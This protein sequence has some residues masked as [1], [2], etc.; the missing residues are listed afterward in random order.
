[1]CPFSAAKRNSH[2][3]DHVLANVN[4]HTAPKAL[5]HVGKIQIALCTATLPAS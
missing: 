4:G 3:E 1:M 2:T 5:P